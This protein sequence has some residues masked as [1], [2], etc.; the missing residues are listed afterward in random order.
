MNKLKLELDILKGKDWMEYENIMYS[1][2]AFIRLVVD[3][4]NLITKTEDRK[5]IIVWDEIKKTINDSGQYLILTC[6][7]GIADDAD[8]E[9]VDVERMENSVTW[10]FSDES[11]WNWEF[12]K[13]EYDAEI[14][15]I[16]KEINEMDINF[17]LEPEN[18]I[19]PE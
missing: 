18:V 11:N 9:L 5:G 10:K 7:C 8:F 4:V 3:G 19:F 14:K 1:N 6:V 13:E 2:C 15:R 17:P 16:E 12:P